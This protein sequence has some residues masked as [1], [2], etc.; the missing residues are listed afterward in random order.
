ME[1]QIQPLEPIELQ[2]APELTA[3][4][5]EQVEKFKS[6]ITFADPKQIVSYGASAQSRMTAF[7]D[8]VL[9]NVRARDMGEVG[10]LLANLVTDLRSFDRA[11]QNPSPLARLFG[12]VR[13]H[14]T[15]MKARYSRV[16]AN[17]NQITAQLERHSR[18]LSK[19]IYVFNEQYQQNWD[20]FRQLSLYIAAGQEKLK[21]ATEQLLPARKA[22]AEASGSPAEMQKYHDLEQQVGR[23]EQKIHDLKL[24]RMISIQLAPQIRLVQNNALTMVDKIQSTILNTLPLWKNQMVLALGIV[25][26]QQALDAQKSVADA[27]NAMLRRNSE[28]LKT[29]TGRIATESQR[30]IVDMETI[31]QANNDLFAA[32]DDLV[33]IQAEGRQKRIAAEVELKAAEEEFKQKMLVQQGQ[34]AAALTR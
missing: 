17:V 19:D 15:H 18:D 32:M 24:S 8:S 7:S 29:S 11:T 21:E 25:H 34:S 27:T 22:E 30:G 23:F 28:M 5:R 1:N 4:E 12:G 31:R 14:L 9:G 26:T 20:Y 33:R 2:D 6:E 13:R 3:Q 10:D 16:E